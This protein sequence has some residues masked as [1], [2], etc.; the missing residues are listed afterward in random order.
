MSNRHKFTYF[1]NFH[2]YDN[3]NDHHY[4]N[5]HYNYGFVCNYNYDNY[6]QGSFET[7][8]MLFSESNLQDL[9]LC[10]KL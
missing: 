6:N 5:N 1:N 2:T 10:S 8:E 9:A 3:Y 4:D 7:Y